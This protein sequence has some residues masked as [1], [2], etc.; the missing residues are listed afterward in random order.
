MANKKSGRKHLSP[1][2]KAL[3]IILTLV[4]VAV[5]AL[6][7]VAVGPK[8][9]GNVKNMLPQDPGPDTS[10]VS[11]MA[12]SLDMTVDEFKT[13]FALGEE[14]TGDTQMSELVPDM[15]LKNYAKLSEKEYS[16][17]VEELGIADQVTE[18]TKWSEAEPKIPF[19]NYVGGEEAFNQIKES[20]GLDDSI[21]AETPWGEVQP[22]LEAKQQELMAA[23]ENAAN[24]GVQ[25]DENGEAQAE[26]DTETEAE[27][28]DAE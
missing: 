4:V 9:A 10:I 27:N 1:A 24:A 12:E 21:T 6:S 11:G 26:A 17:F 22:V 15:S 5:L 28:T 8:I 7:V 23:Q 2:E 19:A 20:Y 13:E 16:E 3:N 14:V 25:T 18:E